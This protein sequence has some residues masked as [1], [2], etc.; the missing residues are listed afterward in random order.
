MNELFAGKK[1]KEWTSDPE[2]IQVAYPNRKLIRYIIVRCAG[3][4]R[5]YS[6]LKRC[7]SIL[8]T[9]GE[10]GVIQRFIDKKCKKPMSRLMMEIILQEANCHD[11]TM[12][13]LI[14]ANGLIRKDAI[15]DLLESMQPE[16]KE[17][18]DLRRKKDWN[19]EDKMVDFDI[20]ERSLLAVLKDNCSDA[21]RANVWEHLD[22]LFQDDFIVDTVFRL[23][24]MY[25][26]NVPCE[27]GDIEAYQDVLQA[28]L[29]PVMAG[30]GLSA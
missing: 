8:Y 26:G 27:N 1:L 30:K 7:Q 9:K 17:I 14:A 12:E 20:F 22:E 6:Y 25:C 16:M 5:N 28:V 23:A 2:Y 19:F 29:Q 13:Q 21:E 4:E 15:I 10:R 24:D 3:A 18:Q 11:I